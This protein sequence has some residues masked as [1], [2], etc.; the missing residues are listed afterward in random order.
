MIVQDLCSDRASILRQ[1]NDTLRLIEGR[2][3]QNFIGFLGLAQDVF[4]GC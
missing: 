1:I 2:T 3:V 4:S